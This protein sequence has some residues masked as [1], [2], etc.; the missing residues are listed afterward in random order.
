MVNMPKTNQIAIELGISVATGVAN[1][2]HQ[3]ALRIPASD[4]STASFP[5][6]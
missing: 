1:A 5:A 6:T 4:H 3:T 2:Q